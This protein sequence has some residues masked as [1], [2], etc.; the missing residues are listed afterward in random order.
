MGSGLDAL[1]GKIANLDKIEELLLGNGIVVQMN[2]LTSRPMISV[3]GKPLEAIDDGM[4][5]ALVEFI[6]QNMKLG[7]A[8]DISRYITLLAIKCGFHPVRDYL[9]KLVWD[10]TPR[11]DTWLRDYMQAEDCEYVN[12]VGRLFLLAAAKRVREP[13]CKF[14]ECVVLIGGEGIGKSSS[15]K[16]LVPDR[17]LFSDSLPLG[18]DPKQTVEKTEGVWI[19]ESAEL[20]GNTPAK[21]NE[22]K[23]FLSRQ[24]DGPFRAAWGIESTVRPRQFIPIATNNDPLFLSSLHGNRRF[25]PVRVWHCSHERLAVERD[26]I[27]AEVA[28]R[29][30]EGESILLPKALWEEA[31]KQQEDYRATDPW[32]DTLA[33]LPSEINVNALYARLS[34]PTDRRTPKDGQRL[35]AIMLKK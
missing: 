32:E 11:V 10:G 22:I 25:W 24:E 30:A 7:P 21:I 14:D 12:T 35:A 17:R 23:A 29:E 8:S 2:L 33:N 5:A 20:V 13:G 31:G 3:D 27:W 9:D 1:V 18:Q 6:K 4:R 15:I 19:C 16:A 28:K 26:Q 34:I